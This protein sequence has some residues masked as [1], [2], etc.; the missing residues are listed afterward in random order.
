MRLLSAIVIVWLAAVRPVVAQLPHRRQRDGAEIY[1][2][3]CAACHG[4]DGRG[5]Q[6][7]VGFDTP[8][9][10]FT[11]CSFAT[12]ESG[13]DWFSDRPRRRTRAGVRRRMPAFGEVADR[14]RDRAVDR[15][16]PQPSAT[17]RAWPRGELNL[18]RALVT[19]KA[20]PENE[21]VLTAT[22]GGGEPRRGRNEL[23]YEHRLGARSQFEIAVPL[24]AA[25]RRRRDWQ[26]GLGDVAVAFKHVL[27]HSLDRGTILSAAAEVVLPTGKETRASARRDRLRAVRGLRPDAASTRSC[28]SRPASS[29]RP[30]AN[31]PST[32]AFWRAALGK[33]FEQGRFGRA[34]SPMVEVLGARELGAASAPSGTSCRRCR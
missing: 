13:A 5:S 18:P 7:T 28:S 24:G 20:F 27:F 30:T 9:P 23:L 25:G 2:A 19:E 33:T 22:I 34:W 3:A 15:L 8:L 17:E 11:D 1:R 21:A 26:H 29:C 12:P 32:E 10:D 14:G 16:R 6:S 4:A 31:A